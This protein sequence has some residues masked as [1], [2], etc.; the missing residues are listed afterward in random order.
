M[1]PSAWGGANGRRL[2]VKKSSRPH[3]DELN[4]EQAARLAEEP[5]VILV[6]NREADGAFLKRVVQELD[7]Q[8]CKWWQSDG[9][10]VRVDSRGGKGQ[11][12]LHVEQATEPAI[13]PRLVVVVDSDRRGPSDPPSKEA[14][15]LRKRCDQSGVPCWVLA[16]RESENYLPEE[17]LL[18]R[19]DQGNE[20]R[21][22]VTAWSE[23]SDDQ[24]DFY[25]AKE[26]L[27]EEPSASESEL[28]ADLN[29]QAR[30]T[31]AS[32]FGEKVGAC[33]ELWEVKADRALRARGRGDLELGLSM[34]RQEV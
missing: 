17:L 23:L 14:Q 11:M 27:S 10:P 2:I 16:K 22:K 26:G 33:W 3:T 7:K 5:L 1:G 19:K 30:E 8:L 6:E 31:L 9:Q 25:D 12:I 24:K 18:A 13:R 34:I 4:P 32:G 21:I 29:N 15:Q 20:L 28:F